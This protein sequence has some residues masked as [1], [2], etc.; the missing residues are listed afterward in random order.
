M[1]ATHRLSRTPYSAEGDARRLSDD[2]V[3]AHNAF[4][5]AL[6]S[7]C[8]SVWMHR[9]RRMLYQQSERYRRPSVPM[10]QSK[11][12]VEAEHRAIS[13]AVLARKTA[14]AC[15]LMKEHLTLTKNI[16]IKGLKS[17][18]DGDSGSR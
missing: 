14:K 15:E 11:R 12:G 3:I 4:H 1:A 8:D 18:W 9:I 7:G 10:V 2:W 13:E 5:E 6:V 16:I 17:G